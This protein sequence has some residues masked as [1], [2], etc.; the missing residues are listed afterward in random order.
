MN[1]TRAGQTEGA[2]KTDKAGFRT[3]AEQP[4]SS[5]EKRRGGKNRAEQDKRAVRKIR[6]V[7]EP[8][9]LLDQEERRGIRSDDKKKDVRPSIQSAIIKDVLGTLTTRTPN[10]FR[11]QRVNARRNVLGTE[12]R[13]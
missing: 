6:W 1:S 4:A 2:V 8:I 13:S 12:L 11:D 10:G 9:D 7:A 3:R 5:R